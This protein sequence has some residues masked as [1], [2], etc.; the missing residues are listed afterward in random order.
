MS[1]NPQIPVDLV[2]FTEEIINKKLHFFLQR[3]IYYRMF[4]PCNDI[5]R[6]KYQIQS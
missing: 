2:T 6:K 5:T 3:Q 4:K 1:P